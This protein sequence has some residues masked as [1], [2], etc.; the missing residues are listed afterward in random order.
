LIFLALLN[1]A[2]LGEE[3]VGD[4]EL[5]EVFVVVGKHVEAAFL[6]GILLQ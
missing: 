6:A 5:R 1:R 2:I 3:L 4:L